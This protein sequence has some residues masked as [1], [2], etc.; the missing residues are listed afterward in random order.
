MPSPVID[1]LRKRIERLEGPCRRRDVLAFGLEPL[2]VL[3]VGV[4]VV[5]DDVKLAFRKSR[6]DAVHKVEK[7]DA[8]TAF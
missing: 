5:E 2:L 1:Q 6:G 8:A 7:L 3:L 4:E